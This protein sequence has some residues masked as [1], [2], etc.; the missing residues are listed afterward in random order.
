[1]HNFA[2][3]KVLM[4]ALYQKLDDEGCGELIPVTDKKYYPKV[5]QGFYP[6]V[7]GGAYPPDTGCPGWGVGDQCESGYFGEEFGDPIYDEFAA[8][9]TAG[10]LVPSDA[11]AIITDEDGLDPAHTM[12]EWKIQNFYPHP[13]PDFVPRYEDGAFWRVSAVDTPIDRI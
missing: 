2:N 9:Y 6:Q 8:Q 12:W 10:D 11:L 13:E 1:M 7:P 3:I 4:I 5:W